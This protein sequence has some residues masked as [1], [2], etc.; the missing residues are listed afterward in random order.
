MSREN[1]VRAELRNRKTQQLEEATP[2][3]FMN[4]DDDD[5]AQGGTTR[6]KSDLS[7]G[8]T[9]L[10]SVLLGLVSGTLYGFGRYSQALREALEITQVQT[11][12]F[13]ILLDTGNYIGH[14]LTG[15]IYDKLGPRASCLSAAIVVF[16]SYGIIHLAVSATTSIPFWMADSGFLGIG[17]GSGLGYIAGLGSTTKVCATKSYLSFAVGLVAA[18]YGLSSTLVG[19]S[20]HHIGLG[21]FFLFWAI[22]VASVYLLSAFV[23]PKTLFHCDES[24]FNELEIESYDS[25]H[26]Q[27]VDNAHHELDITRVSSIESLSQHGIDETSFLTPNDA[28]L[29][30]HL[31]IT[32]RKIDFWL[33]FCIFACVTGCGLF[34]IN[35]ISTMAQSLG[36]KDAFAGT[37][38]FLLSITNVSSR[39][40][41]GLLADSFNKVALLGYASALMAC[42]LLISAVN[43]DGSAA[44]TLTVGMVG[45]AY[46][47]SWVLI[48]GILADRYGKTNFGKDYGL[49][50]MGPAL[51]GMI[52][53]SI[54]ARIYERHS[55]ES[56]GICLGGDC[57]QNAFLL[58]ASAAIFGCAIAA[59]M[60]NATSYSTH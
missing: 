52:F 14:P 21:S 29:S 4:V 58:T 26:E 46:G 2:L 35:N 42:G 59:L 32:W 6:W 34:V 22:L 53:N 50:A 5:R 47:G 25:A 55:E 10:I 39:I 8:V 13:G 20:Y 23:I 17:F 43:S 38:L 28:V 54:S 36:E 12:R 37:L 9:L 48:I 56:D 24:S 30:E 41:T 60:T 51:S 1:N 19:I 44:L 31:W 57:Y 27:S 11:Q 3:L 16:S 18:G 7:I 15:L 40:L 45:V 49:I 33:L